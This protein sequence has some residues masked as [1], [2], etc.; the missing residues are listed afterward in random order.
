[1]L[2]N[3]VRPCVENDGSVE[4]FCAAVH[5]TLQF[6]LDIHTDPIAWAHSWVE[7]DGY[8]NLQE[9]CSYEPIL[10]NSYFS[11]DWRN[12]AL[13][14]YADEYRDNWRQCQVCGSIDEFDTIPEHIFEKSLLSGFD[15][16]SDGVDGAIC[17]AVEEVQDFLCQYDD[18]TTN[19]E[20]L[21]ACLW[22][23]HVVHANGNIAQDYASK[24]GEFST[25]IEE[26]QNGCLEDWFSEE[27]IAEY[28]EGDANEFAS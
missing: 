26:V 14:M 7:I 16:Y 25:E 10:A 11:F 28:L 23:L 20:R 13:R 1:M 2:H 9:A 6:W 3:Y 19:K 27:D 24:I 17:G 15:V 4:S 5:A 8:A 12:A 22:D 21:T 18:A